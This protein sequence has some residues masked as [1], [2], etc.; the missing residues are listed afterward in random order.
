MATCKIKEEL[1]K[2]ATPDENQS[3]QVPA[4]R[5]EESQGI[6][7]ISLKQPKKLYEIGRIREFG[8]VP[9]LIKRMEPHDHTV[10]YSK[11]VEGVEE[12]LEFLRRH[13]IP[14]GAGIALRITQHTPA[15]C[16]LILACVF[17][18]EMGLRV[19]N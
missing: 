4:A 10:T 1:P 6:G 3:S 8:N 5:I 7:E 16:L 18:H 19:N 13:Q 11:A 12:L 14:T 17:K 15:S 9:F 2:N